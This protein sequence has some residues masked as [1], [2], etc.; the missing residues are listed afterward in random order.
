[1]ADENNKCAHEMCVCPV[2][3]D[4]E[5][6][7]HHCEGVADQDIIELRCECGHAACAQ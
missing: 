5:Y 4:Q 7:S 2:A 3:D 6:C 1:M